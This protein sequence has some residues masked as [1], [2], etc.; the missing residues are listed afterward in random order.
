MAANIGLVVRAAEADADEFAARCARDALPERGFADAGR[1]DGGRIGLQ[2][3]WVQLV[4]R[5]EFQDPPLDLL[6]AVMVCIENPRA[7]AMSIAFSNSTDHGNSVSH[8]R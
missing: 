3:V 6:Q 5:E 4:D 8:S 2:A 1:P 7:S